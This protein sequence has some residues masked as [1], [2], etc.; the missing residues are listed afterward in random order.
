MKRI[1][2]L[3][4]AIFSSVIVYCQEAGQN[5][6]V[7]KVK[8][9]VEEQL[10]KSKR[11]FYVTIAKKKN[12]WSIHQYK[13]GTNNAIDSQVVLKSNATEYEKIRSSFKGSFISD[14]TDFE[15]T[16]YRL[17]PYYGYNS[18]FLDNIKYLAEKKNITDDELYALGRSY[19]A[20]YNNYCRGYNGYAI[21]SLKFDL[22]T[23]MPGV[24]DKKQAAML[25]ETF[26]KTSD[27]FAKLYKRN[28]NYDSKIV[29]SIQTK[30]YNEFMYHY[31]SLRMWHDSTGANKHLKKGF[32][33]E[34]YRAYGENILNSCPK[35]AILFS[36]GD[37][38][39]Y[40]PLYM[41]QAYGIRP[42]VTIICTAL[43]NQGIY[44]NSIMHYK[45]VPLNMEVRMDEKKRSNYIFA[46]STE[47][48]KSIALSEWLVQAKKNLISD[49]PD[50]ELRVNNLVH[51][52]DEDNE[53]E[54]PYFMNRADIIMLAIVDANKGERPLVSTTADGTPML[55]E[56]FERMMSYGLVFDI[57]FNKEANNSDNRV[58]N[59]G[60]YFFLKDFK[61]PSEKPLSSDDFLGKYYDYPIAF[62][63]FNAKYNKADK[64]LGYME[65]LY[66]RI[67][68]IYDL[69]GLDRYDW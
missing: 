44:S 54:L 37:N 38:D 21:E 53:I 67:N 23:L 11:D 20:L 6:T 10:G 1:G 32:Y 68:K 19:S 30:Y 51:I 40:A 8:L 27:A 46:E 56:I 34:H 3:L 59:F 9:A 2:F 64:K 13:Y 18:Y 49:D 28:P 66:A 57:N 35:N 60:Y 42:D 41:Q 55:S 61:L 15:A 39:T 65:K 16:L 22:P 58:S 47:D 12:E 52:G 29:G 63:Y 24:F 5:I 17:Q 50:F 36:H 7:K 4:L 62:A 43:L 14:L 26:L 45:D 48:E 33:D 69:K 31:M 25:H